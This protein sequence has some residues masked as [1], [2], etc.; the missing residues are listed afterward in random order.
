ML[1]LA[2]LLTTYN[3]AQYLGEVLTSIRNQTCPRD[4]YELVVIDDGSTDESAAIVRSFATELPIRYFHQKNAGLAAARNHGLSVAAAPVVLFMD[5]D[6]VVTPDTFSQ[7]IRSHELHP[8]KEV[9]VLGFTK[10]QS[11]IAADPLMHFVTDVSGYLFSYRQVREGMFLDFEWFWGGRTSC[12]RN[13]V[14]ESGSFNPSFRFGC[15]DIELGYR[16]KQRGLKV[17]YN[18]RAVS[19]MIRKLSFDSFCDRLRRQGNSQYVFSRLCRDKQVQSWCEIDSFNDEWSKLAPFHN[20]E[21]K[22][23]RDLDRWARRSAELGLPLENVVKDELHMSYYRAFKSTKFA[24][25][26]EMR[27]A[28]RD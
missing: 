14:L 7:H 28:W 18:P 2:A 10:L 23:A 5:D 3:R 25:I 24:G 11:E 27:E 9:A 15:E 21:V 17:A 19:I 26:A 12:K 13:F 1:K 16:L 8:E 6:D 20:I 4:E 22:R